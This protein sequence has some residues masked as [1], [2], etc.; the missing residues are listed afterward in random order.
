MSGQE[1]ERHIKPRLDHGGLSGQT[2]EKRGRK[3]A[4][5]QKDLP[6]GDMIIESVHSSS[7]SSDE[8]VEGDTYLQS[9]QAP[10][11]EKGKGPTSASGSGATRDDEEEEKEIF[12]MEEIIP[13]AYIHIKTQENFIG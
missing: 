9:S 3:I 11:H 1:G 7:T 2:H 4:M 10:H 6:N 5:S 12:V 8:D 13:K